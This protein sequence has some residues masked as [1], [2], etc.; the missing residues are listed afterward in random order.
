MKVKSGA[1]MAEGDMTPMIDMTFQLIAFFMI[2]IN[3]NEAI[4]DERIQLPKSELAQPPDQPTDEPI[5][6]QLTK[7]NLLIFSGDVVP[8]AQLRGL[9]TNEKNF[10]ERKKDLATGRTKK[11]ADAT[12]FIRADN[13][14]KSGVVQQVIQDC[15]QLQFEKFALRAVQESKNEP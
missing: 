10:L 3:F 9:L 11:A 1:P 4:I 8:V 5:T 12:I 14:A 7:D 15:M 2:L 13:R 6:I